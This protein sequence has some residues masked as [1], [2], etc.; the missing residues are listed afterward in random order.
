MVHF[1]GKLRRRCQCNWISVSTFRKTNQVGCL[2]SKKLT[3][4]PEIKEN[5]YSSCSLRQIKGSHFAVVRKLNVKY[6]LRPIG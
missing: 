2:L 1:R 5:V 6:K 3:A 4:A